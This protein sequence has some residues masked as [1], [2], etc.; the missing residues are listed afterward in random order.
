MRLLTHSLWARA[1]VMLPD[2]VAV[3]KHILSV[4]LL[5]C[6]D[7]SIMSN[8]VEMWKENK[9]KVTLDLGKFIK[10]VNGMQNSKYKPS[11]THVCTL[12]INAFSVP[13]LSFL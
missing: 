4:M 1:T 2:V 9:K 12:H 3:V 13:V 10:I 11:P 5:K 6:P 8:S 7:N